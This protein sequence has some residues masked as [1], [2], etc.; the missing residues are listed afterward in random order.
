M[1]TGTAF[2]VAYL[3]P[4]LLIVTTNLVIMAFVIKSLRKSSQ[5]SKDRRMTG[6]TMA[7]IGAACSVLMGTTW[8][9][10]LFAVDVLTIPMQVLFCILNSLQGFFIFIFYCARNKDAKKQWMDTLGSRS[11]DESKSSSMGFHRYKA[12]KGSPGANKGLMVSTNFYE[13]EPQ[14]KP[15]P[16]SS[17]SIHDST[18]EDNIVSLKDVQHHTSA[19]GV[20]VKKETPDSSFRDGNDSVHF[21]SGPEE[22]DVIVKLGK[23]DTSQNPDGGVM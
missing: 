5:V 1:V 9:I 4:I 15:S 18:A 6:L 17:I 11:A 21:V 3:V 2:Y 7:R 8:I 22:V 14:N 19:N 13:L 10:G 16:R 12:G 20:E 23:H